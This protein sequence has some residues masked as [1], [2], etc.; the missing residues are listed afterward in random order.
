MENKMKI[1]KRTVTAGLVNVFIWVALIKQIYF[2]VLFMLMAFGMMMWSGHGMNFLS[3]AWYLIVGT[4]MGHP[5]FSPFFHFGVAYGIYKRNRIYV[6]LTLLPQIYYILSQPAAK[7]DFSF[8]S[9]I[10]IIFH[11]ISILGVVG[12]FWYHSRHRSEIKSNPNRKKDLIILGILGLVML[13]MSLFGIRN[14][15]EVKRFHE[16]QAAMMAEP[17][18]K[19]P[20]KNGI[21]KTYWPNKKVRVEGNYMNNSKEG[22][23]K[24]YYEDGTLRQVS[25]Y[26]NNKL[27]GVVKIYGY[28]NGGLIEEINYVDDKKEGMKKQYRKGI[29]IYESVYQNDKAI[30]SKAY[31]DT[32]ELASEWHREA[33]AG[34]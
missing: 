32:G 31:R 10:Q 25:P 12:V 28:K 29:L 21:Q 1:H 2:G 22:E 17:R 34:K 18:P 14:H 30:S 6:L 9:P 27:N 20:P 5:V 11:V 16:R 24:E 13:G 4:G 8:L 7:N 33:E 15:Y 19:V 26:A 23:F 3:A